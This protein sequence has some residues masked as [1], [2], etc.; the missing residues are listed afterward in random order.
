MRDWRLDGQ[1]W[2]TVAEDEE[3]Y[4]LRKQFELLQQERMEKL[5]REYDERLENMLEQASPRWLSSWKEPER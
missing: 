1:S 2:W 4:F 5:L 3:A